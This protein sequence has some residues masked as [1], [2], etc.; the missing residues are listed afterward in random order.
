MKLRWW[1]IGTIAVIAGGALV[2]KHLTDLKDGFFQVADNDQEKKY[3][4]YPVDESEFE[5][6]DF[7]A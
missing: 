7:L 6:T 1:I 4:N 3:S 2:M 5:G